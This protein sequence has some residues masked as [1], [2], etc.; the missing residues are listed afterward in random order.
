[1]INVKK[2][3]AK[4]GIGDKSSMLKKAAKGGIRDK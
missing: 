2:K 4:G 3:F 1:M